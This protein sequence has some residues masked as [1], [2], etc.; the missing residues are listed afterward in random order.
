VEKLIYNTCHHL[1]LSNISPSITLQGKVEEDRFIRSQ[2]AVK[3]A[4]LHGE[5]LQQAQEAASAK[6][7]EQFDDVIAPL[8][9][10]IKGML[11][12][13]ES[14]SPETLKAIAKW[15]LSLD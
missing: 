8:I 15:K 10:E 6:D 4:K 1:T 3:L 11:A 7:A 13:G 5:L 2:D 9:T 12:P 14:L